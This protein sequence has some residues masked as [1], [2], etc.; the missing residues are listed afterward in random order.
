MDREKEAYE[1]I[2]KAKQNQ[3]PGFFSKLFSSKETRLEESLDLLEKAAN[4]FK[5]LKKWQEAGD[6]LINCA[7]IQRELNSDSANFFIEAAHCYSFVDSQKSI[8]A[9]NSALEVY[10]QTGKFQQAGKIQKQ[11]AEKHEENLDY[12]K[13]AECFK[14]AGDFY[15][16]DSMNTKSYQQGC[17]LK[18]ADIISAIPNY[19]QCYPEA[20]KVS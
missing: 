16:M 1:Y 9:Q 11:I 14:K 17:F 7:Q 3:N 6:I 5:L 12:I 2:K 4:I 19:T 18:F 15:K 20:A 8:D 10:T 13:A